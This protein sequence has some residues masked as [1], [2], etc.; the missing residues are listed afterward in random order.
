[1]FDKYLLLTDKWENPSPQTMI[2]EVDSV[3]GEINGGT[4]L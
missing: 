3:L 2:L 4:F 1:M